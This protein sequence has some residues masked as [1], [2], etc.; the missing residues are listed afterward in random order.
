MLRGIMILL[1]VFVFCC[2]YTQNKRATSELDTIAYY[3]EKSGEMNFP[4][5]KRLLFAEKSVKIAEALQNKAAIIDAKLNL[6][7]FLFSQKDSLDRVQKIFTDLKKQVLNSS[8]DQQNKYWYKKG[9][10]HHFKHVGDSAFYY[11]N[12]GLKNSLLQ[13]NNI[14]SKKGYY[15]IAQL[16]YDLEGYGDAKKYVLLGID[17]PQGIEKNHISVQLYLLKSEIEFQMGNVEQAYNDLIFVTNQTVYFGGSYSKVP[18]YSK[19]GELLLLENKYTTALNYFE[20]GIAIKNRDNVLDKA[21]FSL[22]SNR[23][24]A[25]YCLSKNNLFFTE[26]TQYIAVCKKKGFRDVLFKIYY[27]LAKVHKERFEYAK[28]KVYLDLAIENFETTNVGYLYEA[29]FLSASLD[30]L[31]ALKYTSQYVRISDSMRFFN[32][33]TLTKISKIKFEVNRKEQLNLALKK[34]RFQNKSVLEKEHFNNIIS[35]LGLFAALLALVAISYSIVQCSK[36]E[37]YKGKLE[38]VDA[39]ED[40]RQRLA[41]KLHDEIVGDLNM[42]HLKILKTSNYTLANSICSIKEIVREMAHELSSESFEEVGFK[43]QMINL[44]AENYT[45]SLQIKMKGLNDIEWRNIPSSI[46]RVVYESI[47]SIVKNTTGEVLQLN[48]YFLNDTIEVDIREYN[49]SP[50]F[51]TCPYFI[52]LIQRVQEINGEVKLMITSKG[53]YSIIIPT[54]IV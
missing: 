35:G 46:K 24:Y 6:V 5:N 19:I 47:F 41:K 36:R 34:E 22:L 25:R 29:L 32:T 11:Y 40:E 17:I 23:S 13:G 50:N 49:P 21:L 14:Q 27:R 16:L 26:S 20:K 8:E 1:F 4:E 10:F 30:P 15:Q 28:A 39:R 43:D 37:V 38:R 42:L 54:T 44:V 33:G 9:A 48:F 51:N 7:G 18:V 2:G 53:R 45:S 12:K 52:S 31:N 3:I